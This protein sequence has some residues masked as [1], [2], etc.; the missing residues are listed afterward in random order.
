MSYGQHLLA[1]A[2]LFL[3]ITGVGGQ[4]GHGDTN[5]RVTLTLVDKLPTGMQVKMV[6]CGY[7]HT[8]ILSGMQRVI[9]DL[10]RHY[11][12]IPHNANTS[13]NAT[14]YFLWEITIT[15]SWD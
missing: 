7:S 11:E 10:V 2:N 3:N 4:L 6:K 1:S 13:Q 12:L 15:V 9:Y 14:R 8:V 5:D